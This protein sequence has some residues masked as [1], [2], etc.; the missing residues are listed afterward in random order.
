MDFRQEFV[1]LNPEPAWLNRYLRFCEETPAPA[2]GR[3][4]IK[5]H[6]LPKSLFPDVADLKKHPENCL[7]VNPSGH[8]LAHFYLY[9]LLPHDGSMAIAFSMMFRKMRMVDLKDIDESLVQEVSDAYDETMSRP[10]SE[11]QRKKHTGRP[12]LPFSERMK[13]VSEE[14]KVDLGS[15]KKALIL[16]E[17]RLAKAQAAHQEL[18]SEV[19]RLDMLDRSLKAVNEK[20]TPPQNIKYIYTYPYWVWTY[21]SNPGYVTQDWWTFTNTPNPFCYEGD[22][23]VVDLT[24][25]A[26]PEGT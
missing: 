18:L 7:I 5:H 14:V 3:K 16:V 8:L 23:M 10:L 6:I 19:A 17:K 24:T 2:D 22:T 13:R 11:E 25:N 21:P 15:T 4:K 26:L 12:P 20:T 1:K 9:R